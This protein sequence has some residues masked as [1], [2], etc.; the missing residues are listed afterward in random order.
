MHLRILKE[1]GARP[2]KVGE[3][4]GTSRE[5]LSR[6]H[7]EPKKY[8]ARPA[9]FHAQAEAGPLPG[10]LPPP[11]CTTADGVTI[12]CHRG[13]VPETIGTELDQ[14]YGSLFCSLVHF[15]VHGGLE[16]VSTYVAR[17]GARPLAIFLF[18][19][20]G[21]VVRVVN[22]WM[23]LDDAEASRFAGWLFSRFP[24]VDA[25]VFGAVATSMTRLP[26]PFQSVDVTEDS[27]LS[28]PA[29]EEDFMTL[30]GKST[31]TNIRYY[32][33]KLKREQPSFRFTMLRGSEA[34]EDDIRA[35]VR[36]NRIRMQ[37][38]NKM[39]AND[40]AALEKILQMT[41]ATGLVGIATID[42]RLCAGAIGYR[43]GD[44]FFS[45]VRAHDPAW[46]EYRL[47]R[48]TGY[49]M[50]CAAIAR[51][52]VEYHFLWGR[53]EHK[54]MLQGVER[55]F[56]KVLI[57]RSRLS[58]LRHAGMAMRTAWSGQMRRLRLWLQDAPRRD[59]RLSRVAAGLLGAVRGL[60]G[61]KSPPA[62][63]RDS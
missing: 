57:Y 1:H 62:G 61:R 27:V 38:K 25:I 53:E 56:S 19:I 41:R 14:L 58:M 46:D 52:I 44:H 45:W 51:G 48:L 13:T 3:N 55:R 28:V 50:I 60:R 26:W 33:N 4:Y 31:R 7:M 36:L 15:R 17:C 39:S 29:S 10:V 9:A 5:K 35:I 16:N 63:P 49:L 34:S 20:E 12:E 22:E 18:R 59:D 43:I 47:G 11:E 24:G 54:A 42:G 23:P 6:S 37:R 32:L 8:M 40:D 30:L 2:D 21:A